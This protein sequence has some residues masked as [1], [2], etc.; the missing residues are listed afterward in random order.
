VR[1]GTRGIGER[2]KAQASRSTP[3]TG[4]SELAGNQLHLFVACL[5][6]GTGSKRLLSGDDGA[7]GFVNPQKRPS[8]RLF[9]VSPAANLPGSH[10]GAVF[11]GKPDGMNFDQSNIAIILEFK[12]V[13]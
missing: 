12:D 2:P 3:V 7:S 9:V 1:G 5:V 8:G 13:P 11:P 10:D 4:T 6:I